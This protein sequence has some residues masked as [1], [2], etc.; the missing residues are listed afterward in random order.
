MRQ[1]RGAHCS[2]GS[3]AVRGGAAARNG[4]SLVFQLGIT[5]SL[6][7]ATHAKRPGPAGMVTVNFSTAGV[8]C[9]VSFGGVL[10]GLVRV[11][12]WIGGV[13][14]CVSF[15]GRKGSAREPPSDR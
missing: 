9:C 12:F 15:G 14:C 11:I 3:D 10:V 2:S 6:S 13:D 4:P 8:D 1:K 7:C 5:T